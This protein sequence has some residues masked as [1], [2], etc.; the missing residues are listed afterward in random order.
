LLI[1]DLFSFGDSVFTACSGTISEKNKFMNCPV[2]TL[3][4]L[5][6]LS[7]SKNVKITPLA[8]TDEDALMA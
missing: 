2:L 7:T 5:Y 1:D 6:E 3:V 8:S 4:S